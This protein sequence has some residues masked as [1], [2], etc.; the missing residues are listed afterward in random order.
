MGYYSEMRWCSFES[1]LSQS[2]IESKYKDFI[3]TLDDRESCFQFYGFEKVGKTV[4][5]VLEDTIA[6]HYGDRNLA[7]FV[8]TVIAP[9]THSILEFVGEDGP[10]W[11]YL[12]RRNS[13]AEISYQRVVEGLPIEEYMRFNKKSNIKVV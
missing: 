9:H 5:V 12:I 11:G 10:G 1:D 6:K 7:T 2:E 4:S 8:S 13:V 3:A